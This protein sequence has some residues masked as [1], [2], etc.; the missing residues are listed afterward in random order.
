MATTN[1]QAK[2]L[3]SLLGRSGRPIEP[4]CRPAVRVKLQLL[5]CPVRRWCWPDE[6]RAKMDEE[7]LA[8]AAAGRRPAGG[9]LPTESG[10]G[11]GG[12]TKAAH[13]EELAW[14]AQ[15]RPGL[16]GTHLG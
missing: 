6:D 15:G 2:V 3:G 12:W 10:G 7:E 16:S 4:R 11:V 5:G 1:A 14:P 8:W 9:M 13:E